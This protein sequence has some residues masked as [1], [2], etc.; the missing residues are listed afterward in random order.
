[1]HTVVFEVILLHAAQVCR[2][3]CV[4]QCVVHHIVEHVC[5][6]KMSAYML[7]HH[8]DPMLNSQ[9]SQKENAPEMIPFATDTGKSAYPS[10]VNGKDRAAKRI[11]GMTS[12]RL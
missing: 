7:E 5:G 2:Q 6:Y 1:M 12:L 11:G 10:R 4:M 8:L 9:D 3:L